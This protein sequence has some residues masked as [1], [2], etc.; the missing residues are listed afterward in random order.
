[1]TINERKLLFN[2][3]I[4]S[5]FAH[6]LYGTPCANWILR[7]GW[8]MQNAGLIEMSVLISSGRQD[9]VPVLTRSR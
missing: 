4:N 6:G 9:Q 3:V 8:D 1:M 5:L 7:I 2:P